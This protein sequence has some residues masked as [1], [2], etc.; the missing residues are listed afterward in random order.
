MFISCFYRIKGKLCKSVKIFQKIS[1]TQ[2]QPHRNRPD[3]DLQKVSRPLIWLLY[4]TVSPGCIKLLGIHDIKQKIFHEGGGAARL[5]ETTRNPT[6]LHNILY[7][8]RHPRWVIAL[9]PVFT[10]LIIERLQHGIDLGD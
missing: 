3:R 5:Q 1:S 7:W 4:V 9:R 10:S 6:L 2:S 8:F